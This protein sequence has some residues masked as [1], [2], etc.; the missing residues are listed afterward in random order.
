MAY[1]YPDA[2]IIIFAKAPIAGTVKT[3][4][5][6][7]L[8]EQQAANLHKLM[9]SDT[10]NM[11]LDSKLAPVSLYCSPDTTHELFQSFRGKGVILRQ[12]RGH[13]LGSRMAN[14]MEETFNN[15]KNVVL[16]G[17]DCPVMDKQYLSDAFDKLKKHET[18][19][20]P[21]EDGGYVLVGQNKLNPS[22]FKNINWGTA[23]V[24]NETRQ[25][26][27]KSNIDWYELE[28]LWDVDRADDLRREE[29]L[30][31]MKNKTLDE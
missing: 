18:V 13:N 17:S 4:L 30:A 25:Q 1:H 15:E 23:D 16:I 21:A 27:L 20:G 3:R 29:I 2:R 6:G 31:L 9:L 26:L 11:A 22:M 24:L 12:Q 7:K 28:T 5:I 19:I 14:A 8:N 10:V